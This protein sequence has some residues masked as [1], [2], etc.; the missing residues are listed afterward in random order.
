[1]THVANDH[2]SHRHVAA[3]YVENAR[4]NVPGLN[5]LHRMVTLLLA[6]NAPNTANILVVGAGGGMETLAMA[7]MQPRWSFVGVDPSVPMLELARQT[8]GQHAERVELR[9]GTVQ[10]APDGPFDGA[11]CLLTMHHLDI[12]SRLDLLREVRRRLKP[13][14]RF[15]MVEHSA[16]S[17]EA[18][19]WLARSI[20]FSGRE[21]GDVQAARTAAKRMKDHLTLLSPDEEQALLQEAGFGDIGLF[22]AAF[23]FKGWCAIAKADHGSVDL[24]SHD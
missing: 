11:T 14:A 17:D 24:A 1:M 23:S 6:E 20:A 22:Y 16:R 10:D 21:N 9:N 7:T 3:N 19:T 4:R 15:A 2:F 8:L 12:A 18:E 5:D 13:N